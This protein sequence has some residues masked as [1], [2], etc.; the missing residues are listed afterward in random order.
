MLLLLLGPLCDGQPMAREEQI[1][2]T[3]YAKLSY[4]DEIRIILDILQRTGRDKLW[5]TSANAADRA[6]NGRLSFE[7]GNFHFGKISEIAERKMAE[8][9]GSPSAI[10]GEV[11]DVTPSTYNYSGDKIPPM[12]VSYVKFAWKPSPY[13]ALPPSE[14][15]TV[16][17][18]LQSE[19]FEGKPYTD[20][21]TY[22]VSVTFERR[23]RTYNAWMLFGRDATGA[24]QVYFMDPVADST[25]VLFAYE[26]SMYPTPLA[27]ADLRTVP[28]ID[29]WLYDNSRSCVATY[30]TKDD[31][32]DIC[33]E[34]RSGRCGVARSS[35]AP[36]SSHRTAPRRRLPGLLPAALRLPPLDLHPLL[37]STTS[38]CSQFNVSITFPHGLGDAQEHNSGQHN[39]TATVMGSCT[40]TDGAVVPGPC[41]VLCSAQ[42]S[43]A[44]AEFGGLSG[45]TFVHATAKTDSSGGD[46]SNGG[47]APITCL[48]VSAGTV[49]SCTFPCSTSISITA[50]SKGNLGATISF[51]PSALWNDQNQGQMTCQPQTTALP[52]NSADCPPTTDL[53][54]P[55]CFKDCGGCPSPIIV[56]LSGK[57]F[58]LTD[59]A[60]GVSFDIRGDGVPMQIA[61]TAPGADNGFLALPGSDGLVHDGKQLFGNFTPQPPSAQPNGFLALA[62]YDKPQNGGNGDGVIDSRDKIFSSLRLWIDVNHDGLCQSEELHTLPEMGLLS[63][64]LGYSSSRR[65]DEFGNVFRYKAKLNQATGDLSDVGKKAY[66]VFFVHK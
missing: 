21:A 62:E 51:P 50:G 31:K 57:G 16:A 5:L 6:L 56:D 34:P 22:T 10:G 15:W 49:R 8:F 24:Q 30:N 18:A 61:W 11:L 4:A 2:R 59:A 43:S 25:A 45:L 9:D 35:L 36:R 32:N 46:F 47:T 28:F 37:Q 7:L 12:Y 65:T 66:D 52:A 14:N 3:T 19:Q 40:Y 44:I 64:S 17:R 63:L 13:L 26:H 42:S 38:D 53:V 48:G 33:C 41:N 39:F 29:K 20:Y 60:H 23:S 55:I 27:Q 58:F 54:G 1:I